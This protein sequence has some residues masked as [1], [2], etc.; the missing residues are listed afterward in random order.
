MQP[1]LVIGI[2]NTLRGDDG[3]GFR[4]AEQLVESQPPHVYVI[5]THQLLP[6]HADDIRHARQVIFVDAATTLPPG[7]VLQKPMQRCANA[8]R[9]MHHMSPEQLL[10]MSHTLFDAAPAA[11]LITVGA[12]QF[13]TVEALSPAVE[14]ALP[15]VAALLDEMFSA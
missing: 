10:W 5:A 14:R 7:Y 3:V 13:D 4:V 1:T 12:E 6:E 8:Q 15:E 9:S 11:W 2:G